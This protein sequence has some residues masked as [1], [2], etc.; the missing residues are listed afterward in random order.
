MEVVVRVYE[1][2]KYQEFTIFC[3]VYEKAVSISI[4]PLEPLDFLI[5]ED[6]VDEEYMTDRVITVILN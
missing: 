4:T 2:I 1:M 5:K 6:L 3:F